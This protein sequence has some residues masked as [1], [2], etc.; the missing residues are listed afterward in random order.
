MRLLAGALAACAVAAIVLFRPAA[1]PV[2][3]AAWS[4]VA[5]SRPRPSPTPGG[6]VVYV[7]GEVARPGVYRLRAGSR[8]ADALARAGGARPGADL[9]A[10][11]LAAPLRDGE[12]LVVPR[13]GAGARA[14]P[15]PARSPRRR[16]GPRSRR[17]APPALAL[18][19]NRADAAALAELP[20][21][22]PALAQRIVAFREANGPFASP[23][24][25]LDVAG[26]T[27]RRFADLAPYVIVR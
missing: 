18:D 14:A 19:L 23:D 21:V 25:L 2:A 26:I 11:N 15:R 7:A 13:P 9:V 27:E 16:A 1:P 5:P 20:G 10:V 3:P 4:T 6:L 22:G 8:A 24:E 17:A 12:E